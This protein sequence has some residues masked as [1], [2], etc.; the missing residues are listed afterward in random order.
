MH[1]IHLKRAYF[2]AVRTCRGAPLRLSR[3]ASSNEDVHVYTR[4]KRRNENYFTRHF[5]VTRDPATLYSSR[6]VMRRRIATNT[7]T[8]TRRPPQ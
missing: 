1:T 7:D 3:R 6:S 5:N 4:L 2:S 8:P